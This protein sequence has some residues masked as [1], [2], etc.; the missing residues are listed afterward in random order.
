MSIVLVGLGDDSFAKV[1]EL[2]DE[3][4]YYSCHGVYASREILQFISFSRYA[5]KPMNEMDDFASEV[6]M[7]IPSQLLDYMRRKYIVPGKST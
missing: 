7:E 1:R 5:D 6:L 4:K 2:V 3:V